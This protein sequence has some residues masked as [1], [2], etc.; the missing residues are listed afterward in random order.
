MN[1][2]HIVYALVNTLTVAFSLL[3]LL[4]IWRMT[5]DMNSESGLLAAFGSGLIV[6]GGFCVAL[7][8]FFLVFGRTTPLWLPTDLFSFLW[9]GFICVAFAVWVGQRTQHQRSYPSPI[10]VG[11]IMIIA[12]FQLLTAFAAGTAI[13]VQ[14]LQ[15][16]LTTF[17]SLSVSWVCILQA[18]RQR[19]KQVV[20]L[21]MIYGA[22]VLLVSGAAQTQLPLLGLILI[23]TSASFV[24]MV[25]ARRL[26]TLTRWHIAVRASLPV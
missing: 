4:A 26:S 25:A 23:N 14:V 8:Q 15:M 24:F 5:R 11:P 9:P 6:A 17:C 20:W 19:Q 10:W 13:N 21:F 7:N 3:G 22:L 12:L 18:A 2:T 16:M 1:D